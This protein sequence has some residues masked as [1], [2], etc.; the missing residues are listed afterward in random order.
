MSVC[1]EFLSTAWVMALAFLA[2]GG[3]GNVCAVPTR[4][5]AGLLHLT[6]PP[7]R[8]PSPRQ[9]RLYM[10]G[11]GVALPNIFLKK[12]RCRGCAQRN[13]RAGFF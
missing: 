2:P 8:P 3:G 4:R 10:G 6:P 11:E 7:P 13:K 5:T 1:G 9:A 12:A